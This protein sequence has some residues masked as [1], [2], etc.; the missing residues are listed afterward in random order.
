VLVLLVLLLWVLV[1]VLFL[2]VLLLVLFL[3]VLLVLFLWVL[4]VLLLWVLLV[5]LPWFLWWLLVHKMGHH[6]LPCIGPGPATVG[7]LH[8]KE[9]ARLLAL[10][11]SI[12]L[13][14]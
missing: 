3:W 12:P 14:H 8:L 10:Q 9:P 7:W 5:L 11:H 4:L 1:L 6:P 13:S 2:W